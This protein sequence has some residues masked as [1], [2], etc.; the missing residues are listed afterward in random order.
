[1][2]SLMSEKKVLLESD[3]LEHCLNGIVGR[4]GMIPYLEKIRSMLE[5]TDGLNDNLREINFN[6][7]FKINEK[8][9]ILGSYEKIQIIL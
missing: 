2:S 7:I 6:N 8:S 9:N 5:S 1:M 4:I 3:T